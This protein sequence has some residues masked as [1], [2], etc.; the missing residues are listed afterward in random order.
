MV[1][2]T[3]LKVLASAKQKNEQKGIALVLGMSFE[4]IAVALVGVAMAFV[5]WD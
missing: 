2:L 4:I 5:L 3:R 1:A